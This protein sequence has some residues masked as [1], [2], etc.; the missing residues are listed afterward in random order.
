MTL[1]RALLEA[2]GED[3]NY[4]TLEA[5]VDGLGVEL[6]QPA[7]AGHLRPAP[8]AD[9]DPPAFLYDWEPS[10]PDVVPRGVTPH[11]LRAASSRYGRP[12]SA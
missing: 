11:R 8:A 2:A 1:L 10:A 12:A 4:G 5:A 6:P 3:L 9:G 7:R